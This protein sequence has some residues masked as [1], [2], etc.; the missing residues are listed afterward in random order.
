MTCFFLT[1]DPSLGFI[2]RILSIEFF[3]KIFSWLGLFS[4]PW[5]TYLLL[6]LVAALIVVGIMSAFGIFA[7]WMERKVSAFMQCRLGPMEVGGFHGWAQTIADG[8]KLLSKED[9]IPKAADKPLF[10]IAPI[11]AFVG[12]FMAFVVIPFDSSLI[13]ADLNVGLFFFLAMFG[14]EAI[15]VLMAGWASNNKWSLFGSLRL[16]AQLVTYEIPLGITVLTIATI[17]GSLSV[18]D[19]CLAQ[20][21]TTGSI[22]LFSWYIFRNPF[23]W[24]LFLVFFTATLAECKRAPFDLPE[25][26][27]ELVSGFHTE[28]SGM[29]FSVFFLSEYAA[30]YLVS[31]MIS[32]LF[33]GGWSVGIA[34]IDHSESFGAV[35]LRIGALN[36]KALFFVFVQ[37]WLRWTLPRI[38]LDQVMYCCLK[39]LLPLSLFSFIGATVWEFFFRGNFF[40]VM[41]TL[42][43]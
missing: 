5:L 38:R 12:V 24:I 11:L 39:V 30:M 16:V 23:M 28:Y 36:L 41:K 4:Y 25:A 19:I 18:Q 14:I 3:N 27:S 43:T 42:L 40:G 17:A 35:L 26:E 9:L 2:K 8:I 31:C 13:V 22:T 15:G 1:F 20:T 37:M 10:I 6:A 29:R 33:F 34:A 21:E 7:V 32:I